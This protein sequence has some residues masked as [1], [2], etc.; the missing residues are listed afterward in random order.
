[1]SANS[2]EQDWVGR[3]VVKAFDMNMASLL[4]YLW[5]VHSLQCRAAE[6]LS[7]LT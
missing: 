6:V 2:A 7:P 5:N 3:L 4:R 1:M